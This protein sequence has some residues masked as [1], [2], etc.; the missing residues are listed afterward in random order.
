M[1]NINKQITGLVLPGQNKGDQTGARTANLDIALAKDLDK[2]LY[3]CD[4]I[5]NN[6][7]YS[8]LLYYGYNSLSQQDC[9]EAH[10]FD[11]SSDIYGQEITVTTKKFIRPE[12]R[13]K[14][15]EELKKQIKIDL[16]SL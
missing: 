11:F 13:F 4:I 1:K 5:L 7:N 8:G 6:Q 15:I 9:L 16:S 12:I 10:I 2:G 3:S 14:N